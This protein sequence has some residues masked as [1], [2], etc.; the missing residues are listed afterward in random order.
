MIGARQFCLTV[1]VCLFVACSLA[2]G[3][4]TQTPMVLTHDSNVIKVQFDPSGKPVLLTVAHDAILWDVETGTRMRTFESPWNGGYLASFSPDGERLLLSASRTCDGGPATVCDAHTFEIVWQVEPREWGFMMSALSPDGNYA[5]VS[6]DTYHWLLDART[7]EQLHE[8]A[9]E[10]N[11]GQRGNPVCLAFSPDDALFFVASDMGVDRVWDT[12]T[13]SVRHKI[14]H[15][16]IIWDAVFTPDSA[17]LITASQDGTTGLWDMATGQKVRA[18]RHGGPVYS[19]DL[20]ADGKTIL[21]GA[22][23]GKAVLWDAATG[24]KLRELD[25][26]SDVT[27]VAL[28]RDG[29]LALTGARDGAVTLWRAG[30]GEK[31]REYEHA[32]LVWDVAFAPDGSRAA[33][34]SQDKT[35]MLWEAGFSPERPAP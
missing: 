30:T 18:L 25:H 23:G 28:S 35:A 1:F 33:S 21:T 7:G 17:R 3:Q 20:P 27:C 8:L 12:G 24:D 6:R 31:V 14:S 13:G 5:I 32:D 29:R 26:E 10:I 19:V 22:G 16:N 11:P 34:A 4:V 15:G 2:A 9:P